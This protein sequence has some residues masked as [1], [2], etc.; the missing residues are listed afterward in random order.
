MEF[1]QKPVVSVKS[2]D[3]DCVQCGG[4]MTADEAALNFKFVNRQAKEF[5]C[6]ACLSAR[7]GMTTK[8]LLDMIV[9]FRKQGCQMFSPWEE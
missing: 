4:G 9:V 1:F 5:L 8:Y 6:P 7:T 2:A 3:H